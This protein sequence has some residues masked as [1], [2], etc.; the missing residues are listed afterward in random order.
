MSAYMGCSVAATIST[1]MYT[2][3]LSEGDNYTQLNTAISIC[4]LKGNLFVDSDQAHH[5]FQMMDAKSG[6][7]SDRAIE[8]HTVELQITLCVIGVTL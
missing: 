7:K 1:E 2:D 8:V 6:R 4:L 5:R 3:Q